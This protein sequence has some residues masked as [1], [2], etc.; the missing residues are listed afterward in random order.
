MVSAKDLSGK[1]LQRGIN[2]IS[3]LSSVVIVTKGNFS[4]AY[5]VFTIGHLRGLDTTTHRYLINVSFS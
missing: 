2:H 3:H 5:P 1:P 4:I